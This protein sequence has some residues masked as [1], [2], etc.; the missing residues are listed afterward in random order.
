MTARSA[1]IATC[2]WV[3]AVEVAAMSVAEMELAVVA[4]STFSEF[5]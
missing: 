1:W 4:R 5:R 3:N 2:A